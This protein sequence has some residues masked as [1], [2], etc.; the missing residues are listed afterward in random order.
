MV[1]HRP[2]EASI[3]VRIQVRQQIVVEYFSMKKI[4]WFILI[5]FIAVGA[6][7]FFVGKA[8][9]A[10]EGTV[11][12]INLEGVMVDAPALVT[13]TTDEGDK[14]IAVPSMG[15]NLCVAKELADVYTLKVGDSVSVK[16]EA[17]EEGRIVP[18]M[19][20]SHYLRVQ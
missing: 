13:I 3:L 10:I 6:Y 7:Y 9:G 12:S 4:I 20:A 5:V 1:G 17:D 14:V 18:C 11:T 19:D 16:G 8:S 15:R 2:L